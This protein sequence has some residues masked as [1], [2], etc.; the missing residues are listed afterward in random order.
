MNKVTR[1]RLASLVRTKIF[2][3]LENSFVRNNRSLK[4]VQVDG[5]RQ[6]HRESNEFKS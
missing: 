1:I 2:F 4:D 5:N 6:K 3:L